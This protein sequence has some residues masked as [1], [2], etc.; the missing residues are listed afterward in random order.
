MMPGI[1][2]SRFHVRIFDEKRRRVGNDRRD[3]CLLE[4]YL[5]SHMKKRHARNSNTISIALSRERV[6][7]GAVFLVLLFVLAVAV[8]LGGCSST[9]VTIEETETE[10]VIETGDPV[11][12]VDMTGK[13]WDVS[14][15]VYK[16]G[17]NVKYFEYGLGPF[18]IRPF[19][20]PEMSRPGTPGYPLDDAVH[21]VIGV[22]V[23]GDDR[24]YGIFDLISREVA[25][26]VIG[27]VPLAVAY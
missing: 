26:D 1:T 13:E 22:S 7:D 11:I 14:T 25:D 8:L 3:L 15:A 2:C 21:P 4:H 18:A 20:N 24:G 9:D 17:F 27:G 6:A 5:G 16:Y 23:A 19:I 12:L 10:E